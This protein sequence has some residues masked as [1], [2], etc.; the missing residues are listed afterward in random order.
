MRLYLHVRET[1]R[2]V[3]DP[4]GQDFDT[5]EE[6]REEAKAAA[7]DL[8]A[9]KLKAGEVIDNQRFEICNEA[10]E[11]LGIVRFKDVLRLP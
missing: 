3:E 6:A 4:D 7:R 8:L 9:A 5:I 10:G 2:F 11:V 1:D